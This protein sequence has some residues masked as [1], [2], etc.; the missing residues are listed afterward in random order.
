M[1][2]VGLVDVQIIGLTDIV[3]T[4]ATHKPVVAILY[5]YVSGTSNRPL[6]RHY[7]RSSFI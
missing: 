7:G 2:K 1:V 3:K 5:Y 4:A 6:I